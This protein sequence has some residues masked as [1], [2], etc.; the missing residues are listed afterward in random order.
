MSEINE[1][2][3]EQQQA[4][5]RGPIIPK[6]PTEA[7]RPERVPDPP[8][9][10][11][12]ARGQVVLFLNFLMTLAV[13]GAAAAVLVIYYVNSSYQAPGPLETNTN[14]IVRPGAGVSEVATTLERNNIISDAR[15]FRFMT[16][17]QLKK[18][19]TLKTGEYEIKA[20]ASMNDI[21]ELLKSGKSILYSVSFPEG[22]TVRQMFNRMMEDQVLEGDVPAALPPEG[23]LRPDTYKFSRGTKRAEIIEQMKAAQEKLVDQIW[24]KRDPNLP[25][26]D[27]QEFV[28]LASIVEKETGVPDERAHVASVFLNRL[29]KG[30]RLQSD[31]TVIYGLFGGDGKPAD[32]PIYQSDLRKETPYNTYMIKGLPPA[33]IANPGR[34]ALEAV[35]NPW[36]TNDLYFVADG[37]GGH[38]FAATLE[39]HNANVKRWRKLEADKGVDPNVAVDGQPDGQAAEAQDAPV[40]PKKRRTN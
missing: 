39:E 5:Q 14:F 16:A 10:S 6:S 25:L 9:R 33:P 21:M 12:T 30:M 26:K 22:L 34:D 35:A 4:G 18:G 37:S 27:K 19:E 17:A 36:K 8:K 11:K 15:I 13:L 32:R 40:A 2:N 24:D 3:A 29:Q 38:V 7:L 1:I 20:H 28:T 31:P 23:N